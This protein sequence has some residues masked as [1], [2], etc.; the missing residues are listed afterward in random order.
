MK[1]GTVAV[2]SNIIGAFAGATASSVV[3]RKN[4]NKKEEK[5]NKFKSYYN[6][7]NQWLMLKQEKKSLEIYFIDNGYK[8]VAIYGMGEMGSRL[9]EELKYSETVKVKYAIDKNVANTYSELE[10]LDVE[11]DF[12]EVDV[13]VVTAIFAYDEIEE[14]IAEKYSGNIVSLEDVVYEI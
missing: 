2:L 9:Y 6:M 14:T 8:T 3:A 5:I 10:V 1:K 12:E 11:D 7:L 13:I 4:M